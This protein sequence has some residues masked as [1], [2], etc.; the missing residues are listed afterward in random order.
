MWSTLLLSW[1]LSSLLLL[2]I[3]IS[4]SWKHYTSIDVCYVISKTKESQHALQLMNALD[5]FTSFFLRKREISVQPCWSPHDIETL[6]SL[7][8]NLPGVLLMTWEYAVH[9]FGR[10]LTWKAFN[11]IKTLAF[12]TWVLLSLLLLLHLPFWAKTGAT[13]LCLRNPHCSWIQVAFDISP[14]Y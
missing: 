4:A 14:L 2:I 6:V 11:N 8:P 10:G 13:P 12:I 5:Y 7:T 3:H 9:A 1:G